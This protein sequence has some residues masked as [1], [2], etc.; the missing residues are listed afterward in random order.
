MVS[1]NERI[2]HAAEARKH[3]EYVGAFDEGDS[4]DWPLV[5]ATVAQAEAT[6]ALVE[7]QRIVAKLTVALVEQIGALAQTQVQPGYPSDPMLAVFEYLTDD[8]REGLGL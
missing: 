6:L 4:Q 7:Q 8:E 5:N 1:S 3:L 2:D